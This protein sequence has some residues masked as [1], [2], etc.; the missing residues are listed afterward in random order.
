ML[1]AKGTW[2]GVLAGG[3]AIAGCI[4]TDGS[5]RSRAESI[6]LATGTSFL[7][8]AALLGQVEDP[9][10]F[11]RNIPFFEA[12]DDAI[13][14]VYYYRWQ[15]YKQ[16]LVYT[17]AQYGFLSNEFL[18]P[19]FYGAPYGGINAAAGH[20]IR[21]G[22]WL[23]D[24]T[25]AKDIIDYW[26][27]GPGIFPKPKDESVNPNTTDWAHE[28]SFWA[29]SAVWDHYLATG[30]TSFTLGELAP[31]VAQYHGWDHQFDATLGLYWQVPVWDATELSASS[32]E[33]RDPY[34]G[35]AGYRP[36]LNA[37]QYG[38]AR[39][40]AKMARLAGDSA[41]ASDFD[42]RASALQSA[43]KAHLWDPQRQF[44]YGIAR[45]E[46]PTKAFTSSREAMGFIPWMF[47]MAPP[48]ASIAFRQLLD[49]NGFGAPYGPTTTERRSHWFMHEAN[50]GCCRWN[51]PSWPFATSQIL[52]AVENVLL[53]YSPQGDISAGDYVALLHTYAVTQFKNG[54]PYVAEAH[55]PDLDSWMY[56][57]YNHS[58][59]YN[60]STYADNVISGL[61]GLRGRPDPRVTVAPLA[62]ASWD[63]FALENAPYHGHLL[64][65]LWDRTGTRYG[66]GPGLH[67]YVDG[68]KRAS[69]P[70]TNA[71]T[72][73]VGPAVLAPSE[74][75]VNLAANGQH[76]GH[77]VQPFASYTSP[78]D[79]VW[80]AIDGIVYRNG[81]PQNSRW[82]TYASPNAQDH[83]GIDFQ[84]QVILGNVTLYFYDDAGGVRVPASY[85]LQYW[86]NGAWSSVPNQARSPSLPAAN[87]RQTIRFPTLATSKLRVVAPNR[88]GNVG[89]GLSEFEAWGE[90]VFHL[91]NV[92][93]GKLLAVENA[94]HQAGA[95]VQQ[96]RDNG[97]R[98][99]LWRFVRAPGGQFKIVNENS[100]LVLGIRHA[101]LENSAGAVQWSDDGGPDHV[102]RLIDT[103]GGRFKIKNSNSGKLLAVSGM[104][105]EDSANVVQFE[106][107][108]TQ[109]HLWTLQATQ[110]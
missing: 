44:F 56:D 81:I 45:D 71:L 35:G 8:H 73:D 30:D 94:A 68:T 102:W 52:T 40:I 85:D 6:A 97:T 110:Y 58:E 60:H 61:I 63:Y 72:V 104:S 108:G 19:V 87:A 57:G 75:R 37:Y 76:F 90:P 42:A 12:P 1:T 36:T 66:A 106:D 69:Q 47:D 10:W 15:S 79:D 70:S 67:V 17:G 109:D 34:H 65:I 43:L 82:T 86:S 55:Q 95:Q 74:T 22:R 16:H 39:A 32:Y 38:D 20:H 103:G 78:Y 24:P 77:G 84:R 28:Y 21:E 62:P 50:D 51:G 98:D 46:N 18:T 13:Q 54:S 33:S 4:D 3:L 96:Y 91:V 5:S 31:L 99:H 29:A 89:W 49:P 2:C 25:Y 26:L 64:T 101:S 7:N 88:G 23:R 53:D 9:G 92:H 14:R 100:H 107:N 41:L 83:F 105:T 59:D 93:S 11:E 48:S 80:R 27:N